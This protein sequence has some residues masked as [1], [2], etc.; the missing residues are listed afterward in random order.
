MATGYYR[1][2]A[3]ADE[4]RRASLVASALARAETASDDACEKAARLRNH[5]AFR[6]AE[7]L[8]LPFEAT[9]DPRADAVY[10]EASAPACAR[11]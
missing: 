5:L 7:R 2:D 10:A 9:S 6:V 1:G 3:R 4:A 8:E 11:S